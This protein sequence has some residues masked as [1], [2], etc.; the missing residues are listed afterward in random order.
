MTVFFG[1]WSWTG[2]ALDAKMFHPQARLLR[3][4]GRGAFRER[5]VGAWFLSWAEHTSTPN[6]TN[7]GFVPTTEGDWLLG[8]VRL[9][10]RDELLRKLGSS[11]GT[12]DAVLVLRGWRRW[13]EKLMEFISG[14]FSFAIFDSTRQRLFCARDQIGVAPFFYATT[15]SFLA[16][17]NTL[18]CLNRVSEIDQELDELTVADFLMFGFAQDVTATFYRGS[19]RIAPGHTLVATRGKIETRR[20]WRI[21]PPAPRL[22]RDD[23]Q[24]IEEFVEVFDKAVKDRLVSP[25]LGIRLSGGMDSASV[26]ATASEVT[27]IAGLAHSIVAFTYR[28]VTAARATYRLDD[29]IVNGFREED[30]ACATAGQLGIP[31]SVTSTDD[32]QLFVYPSSESGAFPEP[33]DYPFPFDASRLTYDDAENP[34]PNILTGFGGDSV[35]LPTSNYLVRC[36]KERYYRLALWILFR[37]LLRERKLP[38]IGVRTWLRQQFGTPEKRFVFPPWF[39]AEFVEKHRLT[40]RWKEYNG[41]LGGAKFDSADPVHAAINDLESPVW[42]WLFDQIHPNCSARPQRF[43]HPFFDTRLIEFCLSLP[44][45]PWFR[46]KAILRSAMRN[47]LPAIVVDRVKNTSALTV[48]SQLGDARNTSKIKE[49][50]LNAGPLDSMLALENLCAIIQKGGELKMVELAYITY[51]MSFLSW[52]QRDR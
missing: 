23:R 33:T 30:F 15:K 11:P 48:A 25:S 3:I 17:T 19:R 36:V 21:K 5:V 6:C 38:P 26:A 8:S 22:Y 7:T 2:A 24:Y 16:L 12:S 39:R 51:P 41:A 10:A 29:S 34:P 27:S 18:S 13:G 43:L 14:D 9:D 47:R 50:L 42:P 32:Y 44:Q 28:D 52:Y 45:I 40:D 49:L 35:L 1:L 4:R 46:N 37:T 20:Y 31:I